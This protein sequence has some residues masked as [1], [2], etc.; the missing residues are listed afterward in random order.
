MGILKV[1]QFREKK[2]RG[3]AVSVRFVNLE[4]L[5][6]GFGPE[7]VLPVYTA[8]LNMINAAIK[9]MGGR[10]GKVERGS[11]T[12]YFS[13]EG[14]ALKACRAA[15]LIRRHLEEMNTKNAMRKI[16]DLK[17]AIGIHTGQIEAL[18]EARGEGIEVARKVME[19]CDAWSDEILVTEDVVKE[20]GADKAYVK[21]R[22]A[23]GTLP[24]L[25][26]LFHLNP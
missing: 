11:M 18:R 9:K 13:G 6:E 4:T 5:V 25:Y 23:P 7:N 2:T 12:V 26:K 21:R 20:V 24:P 3:T 17:S 16:A 19:E 14:H 15:F 10:L 22:E 1:L 8:C